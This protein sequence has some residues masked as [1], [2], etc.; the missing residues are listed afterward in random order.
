MPIH[1]FRLREQVRTARMQIATSAE[2]LVKIAADCGF[3]DESHLIRAF[4][5]E[6]GISPGVF[7]R[8]FMGDFR[9]A[10]HHTNYRPL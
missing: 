8:K 3:T 1:T 2:P 6:Y 10:E 7:R 9:K 5:A 4:R